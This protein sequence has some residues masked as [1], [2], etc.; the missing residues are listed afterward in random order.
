MP[1]NLC[2]HWLKDFMRGFSFLTLVMMLAGC[3]SLT[4]NEPTR[5]DYAKSAQED[6][7]LAE[8]LGIEDEYKFALDMTRMQVRDG[9]YEAA[10]HLLQKMRKFR[11]K[12]IEVY[13]LLAQ[14]YEGQQKYGL[15]LEAWKQ[16][17]KLPGSTM[18]DEAELARL[19]LMNGD[20]A[21][22]ETT[23][24]SWLN[25]D[26]ATNNEQVIALNNLG[27][28]ALLQKQYSLAKRY[29]QQALQKDP[30]NPKAANNLNL[31]KT[32]EGV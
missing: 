7:P 18:D 8:N 17:D 32:M 14:S 28:S 13:R 5:L 12:D 10:E 29:F 1:I 4:V 3:S 31:L 15:A 30:L 22:A 2:H 6:K 11:P 20:Y 23:Y 26:D 21:L 16:A 19:A 25:D 27:F 9:R 24:Q